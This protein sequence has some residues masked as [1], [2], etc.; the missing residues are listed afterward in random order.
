MA[1][2]KWRA[3]VY[4][5]AMVQGPACGLHPAE[6]AG[7]AELTQRCHYRPSRGP[8]VLLAHLEPVPNAAW[9]FYYV[10][11]VKSLPHPSQGLFQKF[12]ILLTSLTVP[13][14]PTA[15]PTPAVPPFPSQQMPLSL[16]TR[17]LKS[18]NCLC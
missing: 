1:G 14:T 9:H 16:T 12:L 4:H 11:A 3:G 8:E 13:P 7:E 18:K 2:A 15:P 17:K 6:E 10:S 5:Y